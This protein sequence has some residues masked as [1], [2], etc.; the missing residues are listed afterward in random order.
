MLTVRDAD[1]AHP[2]RSKEEGSEVFDFLRRLEQE[3]S[4][5]KSHPH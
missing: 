5:E 2:L 3:Q 1:L 4:A